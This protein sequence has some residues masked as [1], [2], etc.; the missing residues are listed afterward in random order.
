VKLYPRASIIAPAAIL[1]AIMLSCSRWQYGRYHEK[2]AF[3]EE[4]GRHLNEPVVSLPDILKEPLPSLLFRRVSVTGSFDFSQEIVL[5]NRRH[6]GMPGVHVL[7]PLSITVDDVNQPQWV[8]VS[9]GFVPLSLSGREQRASFH[10]PTQTTF[11][12]IIKES[13]YHR[14]LAPS[15]P[16]AGPSYPWVDAWLRVDIPRISAQLPYPLLP[17]YLEII[18][19]DRINSLPL[20]I[21]QSHSEREEM[22]S[23]ASRRPVTAPPNPADYTFPIPSPSTVVPAGRHR[24][25]IY[26]WIILAV[27]T[28]LA[29]II[30]MLRP[31]RPRDA[32]HGD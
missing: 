25:Y 29:S 22:L 20:T 4:I 11:T 19:P 32:N 1:I 6:E 26:E 24:Q 17:F 21:V 9:R 2:L 7:T 15:D 23:M 8:L 28:L 31:T 16:P 3:I 12:A 10:T 18:P 13:A 14:I 5:R 27:L 30:L